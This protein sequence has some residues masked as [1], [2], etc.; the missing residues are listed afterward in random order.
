MCGVGGAAP[1]L[2]STAMVLQ[3]DETGR[4]ATLVKR[5]APSPSIY[6]F[7]GGNVDSLAYGDLEVNFCALPAGTLVQEGGAE[8]VVWEAVTKGTNQYRADRLPSLY[9]GVQW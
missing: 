8:Q 7:F 3:V 1:C 4:T 2:Y 5:Y 6:S 9:P